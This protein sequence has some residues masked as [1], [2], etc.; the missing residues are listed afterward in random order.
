M[1]NLR[2]GSENERVHKDDE[3]CV[4]SMKNKKERE[5]E[6]RGGRGGKECVGMQKG[7]QFSPFFDLPRSTISSRSHCRHLVARR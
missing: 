7:K 4:I 6:G 1:R 5:E 3:R 2:K